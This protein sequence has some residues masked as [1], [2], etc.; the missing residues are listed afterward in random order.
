MAGGVGQEGSEGF[1][2][3]FVGQ[4]AAFVFLFAF[5]GRLQSGF[6]VACLLF[7]PLQLFLALL[8]L[9]GEGVGPGLG[10]GGVLPGIAL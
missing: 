7:E 5:A 10:G 6:Q 4:D 9:D 2:L 3:G 8:V 1:L